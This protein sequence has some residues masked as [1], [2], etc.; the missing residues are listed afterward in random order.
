MSH[1]QYPQI[2]SPPEP[3]PPNYFSPNNMQFSQF[4]YDTSAA[5]PGYGY[6]PNYT[7]NLFTPG[8]PGG[9]EN[10]EDYENEPPLLEELGINFNHITEKASP[11][12]IPLISC[13]L[14]SYFVEFD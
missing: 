7:S 5:T 6:G 4:T 2:Y 13:A 1:S 8:P 11:F 12:L 14:L 3:Q 9:H 10:T